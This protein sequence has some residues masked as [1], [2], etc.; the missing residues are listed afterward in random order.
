MRKA[1]F[2]VRNQ[3]GSKVTFEHHIHKAGPQQ[4][5]TL[6]THGLLTRDRMETERS[7]SEPMTIMHV[8]VYASDYYYYYYYYCSYSGGYHYHSGQ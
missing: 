7:L 4:S 3:P 2:L 6:K 8:L 5:A 1:L